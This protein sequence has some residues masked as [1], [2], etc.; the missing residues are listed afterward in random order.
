MA[1]L[2][3]A[4]VQR[5]VLAHAL[6]AIG[7]WAAA[8]GLLVHA[9][10][11]GGTGA[12]GA[13]SIAILVPPFVAA[14]LVALAMTRWRAHAIRVVGF[15]IQAVAYAAATLA[16]A[17]GSPTPLLAP[18]VV[19]GLAATVTLYPTSAAVLTRTARSTRSLVSGSLWIGYSDSASSLAGSLLAAG[20]AVF[21]GPTAI[22]GACAVAGAASL[23]LTMW[24]PSPLARAGHDPQYTTPKGAVRGALTELRERPW[25]RG[26]LLAASGRNLLVGAF[27]VLL[28]I[29]ALDLLDLG[30]AGPGLLSACVG[31]GALLSTF[32]MTVAVRRSRVHSVLITALAAAALLCVTLGLW[33]RQ[34]VVF[35]VLA[36]TGV[37]MASVD[38][39]SRIM[40][41]RSSDPRNLGPLF[42][43]LGF[44][45]ACGQLAGSVFAQFAVAV[46]GPQGAL[47]GIG[48]V[49]ALIGALS[50]GS[51]RRADAHAEVPVV[52]MTL[53]SGVPM[54]ASVPGPVLERVARATETI[55]VPRGTAVLTEGVRGDACYVVADGTFDV[56]IRGHHQRTVERGAVV[57]EASLLANIPNV[58]TVSADS[59]GA[60]LRLD[61]DLFLVAL[62]GHDVGDDDSVEYSAA[63]DRYRGVVESHARIPDLDPA[64]RAESWLG[65]GAAGRLLG[66]PVFTEALAHGARLGAD[67]PQ[68][69]AEAAALT[70]WPGAF[71][72]IAENPD[73]DM[74]ELCRRALAVLE[75]DDPTRV[76]VLAT[77]ASHL[78]FASEPDERQAI[79]GE[80]LGLAEQHS[81]PALV[82]AVL[83]AEFICLWEPGTLDR[84]EQIASQ[85]TSIAAD[86][87]DVD[88]QY[89]AG[90]FTAYCATERGRFDEARTHLLAVQAL[91]L[92]S[93][94]QY[95]EFLAE[96]LLLSIDIA[97]CAPG[98]TERIDDLA[99]RYVDTYADTTGTWALQT[100][101]LAY[102]DGSLGS[103]VDVIATMTE[104]PHARTWRAALA[105]AHLMNDDSDTAAAIIAERRDVPRNYFW[106]TVMQVQAEVAATLELID[107]CRELYGQLLPFRGLVGVT[108]SGSLCF[109]LIS[110]SLGELAHALGD[111]DAAVDLLSEAIEQA[112][113]IPMPFES[114]VARRLLA[115]SLRSVGDDRTAAEHVAAARALAEAH[116]FHREFE[117]LAV[118][119][120]ERPPDRAVAVERATVAG[121]GDANR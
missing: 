86:S 84:R 23:G 8:V 42:A 36:L 15:A 85:I 2:S 96:R 17:F 76:R 52:E 71:F 16:A 104:G 67:H 98:C 77:L 109:G 65:L 27:D 9:F 46:S 106:V 7:E 105:L 116:G 50:V 48:V 118:H 28:V 5:I 112:D 68:L 119:Q 13:M 39:L 59:D 120:S 61:R 31:G 70:T 66:A 115:D 25:S 4:R 29:V 113:A 54:F 33:P 79:I 108:A 43:A 90:F 69:L 53:L 72:H 21:G 45:A 32:V 18:F 93:R 40:V 110:R 87:N 38:A 74:I 35:V 114:V 1:E 91:R 88:L 26:V 92:T 41:Q 95:F 64:A 60:M 10:N 55:E 58:S 12:V 19:I 99:A 22:F 121:P 102:H 51:L 34:I 103:L 63:R 56:S 62:T 47:V 82:L 24:R 6:T 111:H 37:C 117:R 94:N 97:R 101:G 30:E 107:R 11:W 44:V 89:L 81:D 100:G 57:G 3:D 14:P 20:L 83:N 49:L 80:A 78:T 75:S 73:H